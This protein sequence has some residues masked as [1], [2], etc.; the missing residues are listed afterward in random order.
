MH[1][2]A[3]TQRI[4]S[5]ALLSLGLFLHKLLRLL[6]PLTHI[7]ETSKNSP[8]ACPALPVHARM[9]AP[10]QAPWLPSAAGRQRAQRCL[11]GGARGVPH[12][13]RGG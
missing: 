10:G 12:V 5:S 7:K 1:K 6:L 9:A 11:A 13:K 2:I 3:D 8:L 4:I